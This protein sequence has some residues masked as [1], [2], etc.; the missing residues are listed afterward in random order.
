MEKNISTKVFSFNP[1]SF[2]KENLYYVEL[3]GEYF[4]ISD[5]KVER[6]YFDSLLMMFI[7]KGELSIEVG[8][9]SV[10]VG[11][12]EFILMDC[13]SPHRY[14]S[15]EPISFKWLHIRGN[16]VFS[17]S[18]LLARKF[19]EPVVI[20]T[21]T[22]IEQDFKLLMGLIRGEN[23]LEHSIS[24]SIHK[25]LA[26]LSESGSYQTKSIDLAITSAEAYIRQNF[27]KQISVSEV[28]ASVGLSVYYFTRQFQKHFGVSPYE[29]L[30]TQRMVNA[31][32][33]LLNSEM[34]IKW[35]SAACGYNSPSIFIAAFK[36]R[37][38][39]TPTQFRENI[40]GRMGS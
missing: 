21:P 36:V 40:I 18:E 34:N 15:K 7:E 27:N 28:A 32:R 37:V 13:R 10:V 38:G 8:D 22:L 14:Y 23:A 25:L 30:T 35:I 5:Y 33:L 11:K 4:G 1:S 6:D 19:G 3:A 9:K 16:S 24:A 12:D 20:K 26:I 39:M 17:Y 31:K 29:Y 2:A